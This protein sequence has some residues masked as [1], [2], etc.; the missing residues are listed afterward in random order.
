LFAFLTKA[1]ACSYAYQYS[2]FPLGSSGENIIFL[3]VE[4]ERYVNTA[5]GGEMMLQTR[6]PLQKN[7]IE[8]R[9]KGNL[10]LKSSEDGKNFQL[11]TELAYIDIA[12]EK[13]NEA[14]LPYFEKAMQKAREQLFFEEAFLLKTA[15]CAYERSCNMFVMELD[16]LEPALN[17]FLETDSK[18]KRKI[19]FPSV[20]LQK[21]ENVTQLN[22]S[23]IETVEAASRIEFYRVWKPCSARYYQIGEK[24]IIIYCIGW[25]QKRG[26]NGQKQADW[27]ANNLPVENFIEGNDVMMHGQ[28]FDIC[29]IL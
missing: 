15:N 2:L 23:E 9:W 26:Y 24:K 25:G 6:D 27:K 22:F 29:Q 21:Y 8:T 17:C 4:L 3:E 28:R 10:R 14:L 11:I 18:Q 20:L 7:I 16:T 5:I 13:Y 12:D 1:A 19:D